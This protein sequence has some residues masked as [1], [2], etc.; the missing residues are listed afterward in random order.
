MKTK[1]IRDKML[2]LVRP[3]IYAYTQRSDKVSLKLWSQGLFPIYSRVH[4]QIGTI[5]RERSQ[6]KR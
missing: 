6:D 4:V 5:V 1:Q 2:D 3:N